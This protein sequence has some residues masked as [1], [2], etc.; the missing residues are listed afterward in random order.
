MNEAGKTKKVIFETAATLFAQESYHKVSMK[1]IA[2]AVG[3]APPSIYNHYTSKEA[4]LTSIYRFF[5]EQ[6]AIYKP[7]LNE[8][9]LL[10]ET[11]HPHEIMRKTIFVYPEEI[12]S[13]IN[14]SMLVT[15][16]MMRS[17]IRANE[18]INRNLIRMSFEYDIPILEKLLALGR[19]EPLD[20]EAFALLHS[21]YQFSS[22]VRFYS[23]FGIH[24]D[25]WLNGLQLLFSLIKPIE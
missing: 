17:D 2:D 15:A 12:N 25:D 3:I 5:D 20:I 22:A 10:C 8:L 4:I 18:I 23:N 6:T 16:S 24:T 11:E 9:L 1:H 19:I 13:L 21:N 14:Y 7:N